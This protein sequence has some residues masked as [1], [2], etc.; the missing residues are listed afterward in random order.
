ME[1][2]QSRDLPLYGKYFCKEGEREVGR[3]EESE[4]K[5]EKRKETYLFSL[6]SYD[7]LRLRVQSKNQ[8]TSLTAVLPPFPQQQNFLLR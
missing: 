3:Q 2:N 8:E 6:V 7:R 5:E 1:P 4:K